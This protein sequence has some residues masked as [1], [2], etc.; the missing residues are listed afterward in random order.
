MRY[1]LQCQFTNSKLSSIYI[2][3]NPLVAQVVCD[4]NDSLT[5]NDAQVTL[6]LLK[7]ADLSLR[8]LTD[9]CCYTYHEKLVIA[10]N[11]K[12]NGKQIFT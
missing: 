2:I 4:I 3:F 1:N 7:S 10:R 11:E 9:E 6:S 12:L 8:S 5:S